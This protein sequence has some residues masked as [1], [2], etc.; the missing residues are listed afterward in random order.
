MWC[1]PLLFSY[2]NLCTWGACGITTVG[3]L[4]IRFIS[5]QACEQER[6]LLL[7]RTL[8]ADLHRCMPQ[9]AHRIEAVSSVVYASQRISDLD[10]L[11]ALRNMFSA[12]FGKTYVEQ[13]SWSIHVM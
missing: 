4:T 3:R 6:S 13:V 7:C 11:A 10:E 9:T 8:S 5:C 1:R 2:T 12:K